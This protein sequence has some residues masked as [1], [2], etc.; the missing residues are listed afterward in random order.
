L[1]D[2][3]MDQKEPQRLRKMLP[4]N[5]PGAVWMFG[6]LTVSDKSGHDELWSGYSRQKGLVPPDERGIARFNDELGVFEKVTKLDKAEPWRFP[7]GA[8]MKS[9]E[10]GVDWW[11]FC[12]PFPHTRVR[13][14][15]E[16]VKDPAAYE[17]FTWNEKERG[18]R[19][20]KSAAP[21]TQA[22]ERRLMREGKLPKDQARF[23][24]QDA[25]SGAEISVHTAS[26]Q[27]NAWRK[28]WIITA[29][30]FGGKDAPSPLG[31]MWYA[32]A[33]SPTGPWRKAINIASHPRYSFYNPVHHAFLDAEGGRIIYFEGTYTLEFSGNPI[34]PARYDYNQLC[35]RLDLSDPR[36]IPAHH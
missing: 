15:A 16:A 17:A 22:E 34:A 21:T 14:T 5:E 26:V 35:Y 10:D 12:A 27:W 13:A 24:L 25:A 6:L 33:N 36:L 32:E 20:Q 30:Q 19:W 7:N 23:Q 29:L 11:Y 8:S 1:Y 3:F 9:T 31:E 2:Y 18:W 28:K 4:E